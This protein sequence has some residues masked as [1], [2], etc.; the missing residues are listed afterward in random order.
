MNLVLTHQDLSDLTGAFRS[1]AQARELTHLGIPYK[2]RRDG[3]II[4]LLA[5]LHGQTEK[6]RQASPALRLP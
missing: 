3:T 1:D 2:I 5:D 6:D 4:V